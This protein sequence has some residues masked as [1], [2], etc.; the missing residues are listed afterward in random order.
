MPDDG[1]SEG[2]I[3]ANPRGDRTQLVIDSHTD[4]SSSR[5]E[6]RAETGVPSAAVDARINCELTRV[7]PQPRRRGDES[8]ATM[9]RCG[10]RLDDNGP[11]FQVRWFGSDFNVRLF[12]P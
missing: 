6:E 12:V 9:V 1:L 11:M 2:A 4:R 5:S 10:C 8:E 3:V 7:E